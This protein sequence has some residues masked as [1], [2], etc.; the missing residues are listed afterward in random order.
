[1]KTMNKKNTRRKFFRSK[2]EK[3]VGKTRV[4]TIGKVRRGGGQQESE[5]EK[6]LSSNICP[7]NPPRSSIHGLRAS[8][9]LFDYQKQNFIT[10]N[11]IFDA[12]LLN[13]NAYLNSY[14]KMIS[15]I[16]QVL[17]SDCHIHNHLETLN[18]SVSSIFFEK[19]T[20]FSII[21]HHS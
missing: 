19:S 13:A 11:R 10:I 18:I 12:I 4:L 8:F 5:N 14:Q 3:N 9:F 2:E 1:M 17:H 15:E 16:I 21:L 7:E 6:H 20:S